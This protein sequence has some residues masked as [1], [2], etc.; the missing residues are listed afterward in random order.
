MQA[1]KRAGWGS[2]RGIRTDWLVR[3]TPM[4]QRASE[5][6]P[7]LFDEIEGRWRTRFGAAEIGRLR[8]SL[9]AVADQLTLELPHAFPGSSPATEKYPARVS[10]GVLTLPALLSQ[11]LLAF[12]LEFD[13]VSK[14]PLALCANTIRVLGGEKPVRV[15]D[16]ARLTGAS[17]ETSGIGWQ[18]KPYVR[19]QSDPNRIRGTLVE[20][21]PLGLKAFDQYGQLVREIERRWEARFGKQVVQQ[22]CD[23]L[24]ALFEQGGGAVMSKGLVPPPG[25]VRAG[26]RV[27]AL[28]RKS[29]APAA[30]QRA[31]DLVAQTEEFVRDPAGAL[32]HHPLWDMNRGFG[33]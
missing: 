2:G 1:G 21:T 26:D 5:I 3:L 11:V 27:P 17:P 19:V 8:E 16:I 4:G 29:V 30:L 6:W 13:S 10:R 33:P 14:A 7:P 25:V 12:T 22:L 31:R 15:A 24:Q 20:L 32:P 18:I 23:A 9:E 28:G